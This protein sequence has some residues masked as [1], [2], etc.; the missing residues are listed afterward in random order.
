MTNNKTTKNS[1]TA[2]EGEESINDDGIV[3]LNTDYKTIYYIEN[4]EL[5]VEITNLEKIIQMNNI[6]ITTNLVHF[7][8]IIY[9]WV[10]DKKYLAKGI[11]VLSSAIPQNC[12]FVFNLNVDGKIENFENNKIIFERWKR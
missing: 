6:T 11:W 5:E 12:D 8:P 7:N 1:I 3:L 2:I 4:D 9:I 10:N